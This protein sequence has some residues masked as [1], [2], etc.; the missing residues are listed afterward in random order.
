MLVRRLLLYFRHVSGKLNR[1]QAALL[2]AASAGLAVAGADLDR[3]LALAT[4]RYGPAGTESVQAWRRLLLDLGSQGE[5]AKIRRVNE[6]FNRRIQF[7]DD[8]RIWG[9]SD[10]W[11]TPLEVLGRGEGD[12]EDFAV[13]KYATLKLLGISIDKLRLTYVKARIGG[14]QGSTTQAHMVLTYYPTA[15]DEPLVLDNLVS[16]VRPASGRADLSPVFSFNAE[17]LWVGGTGSRQAHSTE[18]LSRWRTLLARMH[19]EGIE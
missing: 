15:Q 7:G 12:C 6:F 16:D 2:L 13:A 5:V 1:R 17:G 3:I 14:A 18:R 11:A 9:V 10:Y 19:A 4:Q 8:E